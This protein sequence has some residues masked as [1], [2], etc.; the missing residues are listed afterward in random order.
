MIDSIALYAGGIAVGAIVTTLLFKFRLE[1]TSDVTKTAVTQTIQQEAYLR[2]TKEIVD[3][4]TD[5]R[6]QQ[7]GD[8]ILE[9]LDLDVFDVGGES[10]E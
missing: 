4:E 8:E 6:I 3:D 2:A 9:E 10:S 1:R 7:R 5:E